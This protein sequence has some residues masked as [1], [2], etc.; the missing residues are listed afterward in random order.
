MNEIEQYFDNASKSWDEME[1]SPRIKEYLYSLPLKEGMK[2]LDVACG[3]GIIT[4]TLY[5]I[6]KIDIEAIDISSKMIEKAKI[7][8]PQNYLHF[9]NKDF[10]QLQNKTY[11]ALIVFD[12]YPHFLDVTNF[13]KKS[14]QLLNDNGYLIILHDIGKKTLSEHH[15]GVN[16]ISRTLKDVDKEVEPFLKYFNPIKLEEDENHY[17]IILKKK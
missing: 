14:D 13:V 15:K 7:N 16:N 8:H 3:T 5:E 17:L 2:V 10:Y 6:V 11:D 1:R 12:V 9:F 4:E